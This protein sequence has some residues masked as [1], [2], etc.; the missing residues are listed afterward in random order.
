M[1]TCIGQYIIHLISNHYRPP[2]HVDVGTKTHTSTGC[3]ELV[4]VLHK[5][6]VSD[7]A[8]NVRSFERC[9]AVEETLVTGYN[10]N[11]KALAPPW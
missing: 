5:F 6:G 8:K 9:A 7:S 11:G 1:Y 10:D 3:A 2:L 4:D